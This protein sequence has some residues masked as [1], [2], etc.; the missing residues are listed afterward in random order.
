MAD[1]DA[2]QQNSPAAAV[3]PEDLE[4]L[5]FE[6]EAMFS[7]QLMSLDDMSAFGMRTGLN[8]IADKLAKETGPDLGA[9]TPPKPKKTKKT[10]RARLAI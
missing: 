10:R 9:S 7:D 6:T 8:G 2:P 5:V 3:V 1:V 4:R